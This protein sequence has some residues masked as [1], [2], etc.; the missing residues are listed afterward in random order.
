MA[1]DA[2]WRDQK[3]RILIKIVKDL[4]KNKFLLPPVHF[5]PKIQTPPLPLTVDFLYVRPLVRWTKTKPRV[6]NCNGKV[7][8]FENIP[9]FQIYHN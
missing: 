7:G 5:R 6:F 8:N 9:K 1:C 3:V 2:I 4:S